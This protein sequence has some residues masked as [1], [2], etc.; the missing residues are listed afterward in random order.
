M[1]NSSPRLSR[2][3][4]AIRFRANGRAIGSAAPVSLERVVGYAGAVV[5]GQ[6]F[7]DKGANSLPHYFRR[8]GLVV[9]VAKILK[10]FNNILTKIRPE[11]IFEPYW[12]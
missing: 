10:H 6:I 1:A 11:A 5:Q 9:C 3:R 7:G 2:L 12:H 8:I 4:L